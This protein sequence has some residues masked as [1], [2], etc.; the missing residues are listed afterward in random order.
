VLDIDRL[1]YFPDFRANERCFQLLTQVSGRAGRREKQGKVI[2]QTS[3]PQ[4]PVL[5]DITQH[6][7]ERMYRREL[8]ER[9]QFLYPP[10]VRLI[11]ITLKHT[12][13]DLVGSA[14]NMLA[15]ELRKQLGNGVL[16]PQ[17]PLITKVRNQYLM[18]I[19]VKIKKD[20]EKGL[21]FTKQVVTQEGRHVV[22]NKNFKQVKVL[23]DV[24]PI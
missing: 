17:T 3:N 21:L 6:D 22:L 12:D 9:K 2:I 14:A 5:K 20:T 4:H 16:G 24:D 10:Y 15:N 18:D 19:W 7:Y 8:T 1:L 23:F 11:R 13:K